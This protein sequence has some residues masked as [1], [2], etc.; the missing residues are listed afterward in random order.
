MAGLGT[1]F[2]KV[3]D[4]NPEFH[5]PKP[6]INVKKWPMV[7]WATGSL[8]FFKHKENKIETPISVEGKDVV[9]IVLKEHNLAHSMEQTL[10]DI[11]SPDVHVVVLDTVTRGATE[12]VYKAKHLIDP[13][14]SLLVTDSDHFFDGSHLMKVIL[15]KGPDTGGVIPVFRARNEGIPKW[16]YSLIEPETNYIQKVGEKDRALMEAG[17]YA[18]IGAYY[19]SKGKYFLDLAEEVIRNNQT[20]GDPGKA[21]FYV[22]PLFQ[23]L[24]EHGHK[25]QAAFIP[26][27]WGLGTPEDLEHFLNNYQHDEPYY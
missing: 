15:E 18:N 6:F 12:T 1:R 20:F 2:K 25:V 10:K 26:E 22:A 27:V 5:K 7:R 4:Q 24:L 16:S 9:F 3:A 17:A 13:E 21:E 11:Y 19:F 23:L 14:D 8:P